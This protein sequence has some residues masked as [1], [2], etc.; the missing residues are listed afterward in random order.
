MDYYFY[1]PLDDLN[2]IQ[3]H[4]AQLQKEM[5]MARRKRR[6]T[7]RIEETEKEVGREGEKEEREIPKVEHSLAY[8][9]MDD[10][11]AI[12][13]WWPAVDAKETE[14]CFKLYVE[15]PG[16]NKEDVKIE[17]YKD[18]S[19]KYLV[20]S[21]TK[22]K[23]IEISDDESEEEDDLR[24]SGKILEKEEKVSDEERSK[25]DEDWGEVEEKVYDRENPEKWVKWHRTERVFGRFERAFNIPADTEA[26]E[27]EAKFDNGVLAVKFPKHKVVPSPAKALIK[28]K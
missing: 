18:G 24:L 6:I 8:D 12:G 20:V 27:I 10:N 1:D 14:S 15:L 25:E 7:Q 13:A 23:A 21:G 17:L 22:E 4:L 26:N 3:T 28:I 2:L 9:K 5:D 19:E 16:V 11:V